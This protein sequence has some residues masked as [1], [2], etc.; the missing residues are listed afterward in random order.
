MLDE[1][2][3][4]LKASEAKMCACDGARNAHCQK[5]LP[6]C[7]SLPQLPMIL[8]RFRPTRLGRRAAL[9]PRRGLPG[10]R[11]ECGRVEPMSEPDRFY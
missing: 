5:R 1:R 7:L 9:L 3:I 2:R 11:P 10:M 8:E 6:N 4:R